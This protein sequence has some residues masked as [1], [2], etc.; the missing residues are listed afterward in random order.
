MSSCLLPTIQILQPSVQNPVLRPRI[1]NEKKES[2]S[3]SPR[4]LKKYPTGSSSTS[5]L[6]KMRTSVL[7]NS[8]FLSIIG[9]SSAQNSSTWAQTQPFQVD[10][11]TESLLGSSQQPLTNII[12]TNTPDTTALAPVVLVTNQFSTTIP[13]E[14]STATGQATSVVTVTSSTPSESAASSSASSASA[15]RKASASRSA[16]KSASGGGA[17]TQSGAAAA[18]VGVNGQARMMGI[19]GALAGAAGVLFV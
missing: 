2:T 18:P 1:I 15:S 7:R 16:S 19:A 11:S 6:A 5:K 8:A 17:A 10:V 9:L 13:T 14:L 3:Q 4:K 12:G